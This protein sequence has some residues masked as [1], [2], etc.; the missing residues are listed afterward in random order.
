VGQVDI[1]QVAPE[2]A[3]QTQDIARPIALR[4]RRPATPLL[5]QRQQ[6]VLSRLRV[7]IGELPLGESSLLAGG[8][9]RILLRRQGRA[10]VA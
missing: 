5:E 10:V 2:Q 6:P 3:Q 8:L 1:A 4:S 7:T 9:R